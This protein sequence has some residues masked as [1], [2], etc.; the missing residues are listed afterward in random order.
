MTK[1]KYLTKLFF[2]RLANTHPPHGPSLHLLSISSYAYCIIMLAYTNHFFT[3]SPP[4]LTTPPPPSSIDTFIIDSAHDAMGGS[5]RPNL[6]T[7]HI[8]THTIYIFKIPFIKH[9]FS[10]ILQGGGAIKNR[11]F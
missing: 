3:S 7:H 2:L 5:A 4:S 1:N 8:L 11:N 9:I 6:S 10:F